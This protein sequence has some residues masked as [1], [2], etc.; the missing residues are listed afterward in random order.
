M[1][2]SPEATTTAEAL[3]EAL[4]EL[5]VAYVFANLG[6]DHPALIEALAEREDR[7][8]PTPEVILSP[9]EMSAMS[10]AQGLAMATGRTQCVLVHTDVG[11]ANLGGSVHNAA[12]SR[13]PVLVF[14]GATPVTLEGERRGTR[15]S[16]INYLQDVTDQHGLVREYV[17]WAYELR[18]GANVKQS[19]YR[20]A[21][22]ARSAPAGPVYLTAARE[23]LAEHV[24]RVQLDPAAWAPVD[25]IPLDET[26]ARQI[27][28]DLAGADD[29]L[30]ITSHLGRNRE[31][32]SELVHLAETWGLPVV[33]VNPTHLNFPADHPHHL[34]YSVDTLLPQADVVLVLDSDVPWVQARVR[35]REGAQVYYL[36]VDPLKE[37]L[38]LWYAPA[39]RFVRV[40]THAALVALN[41]LSA[42]TGAPDVA[43][44]SERIARI[45]H[46]QRREWGQDAG[47]SGDELTADAVAATL[48]SFLDDDAILV[49]E[50]ITNAEAIFRNAPRSRPGTMYANGGSSL[51]WSG[52][53]A[54]GVKLANPESEVVAVIGDGSFLLSAPSS[55]YWMARTY[56]VAFTTIVL[57]NGGW[58][59]TKQNVLRQYPTGRAKQDDKFW[60]SL[61]RAADLAGIAAA[62]G[63]AYARTVSDLEGL[64]DAL[65]GAFESTA[66]GRS[67]VIDV[68]LPAIS[69][70]F[71]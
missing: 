64:R 43:E 49:N 56:G 45:H 3:I 70:Q 2:D 33:E 42:Q 60:V 47:G 15:D 1:T 18:T 13:V 21:Q 29:P 37:R 58:N 28:Q 59:A 63:G 11:T 61:T 68:R 54:L 36:D 44:R 46:A 71:G 48:A 50:A 34:G 35:P 14:A 55:T 6:S 8:L 7:G 10:A 30:V 25:P 5:D 12:R 39:A 9:H 52:G 24:D 57:N 40:D 31:S 62:A 26:T 67:A 27:L 69:A 38:P 23:V 65:A 51:G 17:K 32:V 22:L 16:Y 19:V 41:A 66:S 4:V 20:G 53:G